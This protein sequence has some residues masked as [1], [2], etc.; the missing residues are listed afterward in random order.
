[1]GRLDQG[2]QVGDTA[3]AIERLMRGEFL[4]MPCLTL[5]VPQAMRLWHLD[6]PVCRGVLDSLVRAG[7]LVKTRHG[8][9]RRREP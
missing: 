5:T 8:A 2:E 1:M 6:H 9:F 7:F 3:G 4:E